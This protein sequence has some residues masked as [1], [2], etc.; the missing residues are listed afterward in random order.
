MGQLAWLK[1]MTTRT[2]SSGEYDNEI[3]DPS[4]V[5][6]LFDEMARTYGLV[7]LISSFGF[8]RIWR[9]QCIRQIE[10]PQGC[11]AVDLMTGMGELCPDLAGRVGSDGNILAVDIS[12]VMCKKARRY[13]AGQLPCHIEVIEADALCSD[14]PSD[15]ADVVVSSFGLKT[16]STPQLYKLAEE[17]QRILKPNGLFSFVEIS[18]P[19]S[20]WLRGPY[21]FYLE[22]IIPMIGRLFMGNPEN[23]RMLNVYTEAFS[24][25]QSAA[26]AFRAAGLETSVRRFFFGC[27]TGLVGRKTQI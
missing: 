22:N 16:F 19:P 20:R 21:M 7:N 4:F 14:L 1:S 17:V 3:Y 10:I 25:C 18:V 13:E 11:N 5:Q 24:N 9:R 2:G 12:P 26:T 23:Y 15:H 27:A 6:Q 8:C